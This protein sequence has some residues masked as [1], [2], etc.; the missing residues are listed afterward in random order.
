MNFLQETQVNFAWSYADILGLDPE[1]V[2]HNLVVKPNAKLVKQKFHK[3]HPQVFLLVKS[4]L[5]KM[6]DVR[7]IKHIDYP[8]W[9]SNIVP[10]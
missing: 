5:Q 6:L 4:E 1:L 7:F 2:V 9:V 10:V 8:E 3:I